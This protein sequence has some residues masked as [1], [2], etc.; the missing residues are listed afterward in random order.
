M[1]L[2]KVKPA[3]GLFERIA[4]ILLLVENIPDDLSDEELEG[5]LLF[6]PSDIKS[7]ISAALQP[8]FRRASMSFLKGV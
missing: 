5:L 8:R 2:T 7:T 4:S 1:T 6:L 3:D